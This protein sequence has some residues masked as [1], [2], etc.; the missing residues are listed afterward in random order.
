MLIASTDS[1]VMEAN[2]LSA[3]APRNS[4]HA[5]CWV[6]GSTA[7]V[8]HNRVAEGIETTRI[9]LIVT[10]P[11]LTLAQDNVMTHCPVVY[12]GHNHNNPLYFHEEGDLHWFR[13][14]NLRCEAQ[15]AQ[16]FPELQNVLDGLFGPNAAPGPAEPGGPGGVLTAASP[17]T[18]SCGGSTN[19]LDRHFSPTT[20]TEEA[21]HRGP[22]AAGTRPIDS[23]FNEEALLDDE[24][25][26]RVLGDVIGPTGSPDD[27][28]KVALEIGDGSSRN[29]SP[30]TAARR[31]MSA[32]PA[33][34]RRDLCGGLRFPEE[35]GS[36]R[37]QRRR[38]VAE[39]REFL[40]MGPGEP[41][42]RSP[43][44]RNQLVYL[45][46]WSSA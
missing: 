37:R 46:A 15:A 35:R 25:Q 30:T 2:Q 14:G 33:A 6:I 44:R 19:D 17:P 45:H 32:V 24:E 11:M 29:R 7:N 1:V 4:L 9:S 8:A 16:R 10:A 26:R 34:S 3:E 21:L 38:L 13:M 20:P 23:D 31:S 40:Q 12:G 22:P 27:G 39:Q 42:W 18:P 36:R 41:R 28:F 43:A 5:H